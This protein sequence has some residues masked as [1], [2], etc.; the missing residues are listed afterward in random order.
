MRVVVTG[1][2]GFIGSHLV[3]RLVADGHQVGVI[4]DLSTGRPEQVSDQARLYQ[5]S[6]SSAGLDGVVAEVKPVVIFHLAAQIDVRSSVTDPLHDAEVNVMGTVRLLQAASQ[7]KV[8]RVVFVSSGG[9]VYGDTAVVPTPESHPL[10]PASP[11]GAAKAAG[12]MYLSAFA[13]A[14][15]IEV[16]ILRPGNVYGPR[17]DPHGE[18]G[19]IAIFTSQ[20]L[21]GQP[22]VIN[23]DGEQ[24][25]D[26]VYVE[27]VVEAA[28]QLLRGPL[29]AYNIGTGH[30]TSVSQTA[31]ELARVVSELRPGREPSPTPLHGPARAGEQ[32]RS[33]L[34]CQLAEKQLGWTARV[35]LREGLRRTVAH[36]QER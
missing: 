25:R 10:R 23:G 14:F 16:A 6:V 28:I 19:V 4:D 9:A 17:Q 18:A 32:R 11:Y 2:A 31:A 3:D 8:S 20:L 7:A 30:E 36:F 21:A 34:D 24:T 1:G 22:L 29:G 33:C 27:D 15:G 35:S 26:Y 5:V 12:E 13:A